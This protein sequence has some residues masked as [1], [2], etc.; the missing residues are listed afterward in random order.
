MNYHGEGQF[1]CNFIVVVVP[2]FD[3]WLASG[4]VWAHKADAGGVEEHAY[5]HTPFI[6]SGSAHSSLHCVHSNVP[7][8][9]KRRTVWDLWINSNPLKYLK[10]RWFVNHKTKT[11]VCENT[12]WMVH[13]EGVCRRTDTH[14]PA[15]LR[16]AAHIYDLVRCSSAVLQPTASD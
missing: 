7:M 6:T 1:A 15:A 2:L 14:P 4:E 10:S 12:W 11:N 3:L 16:P 8:W 13:A 5:S 9:G